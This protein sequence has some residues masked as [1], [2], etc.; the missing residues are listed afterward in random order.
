MI[1]K[2]E[3]EIRLL[4]LKVSKMANLAENMTEKSIEG[5]VKEDAEL[6]EEVILT[7]KEVDRIDNEIDEEVIRICA[8]RQP[9]AGDLRFIIASLKINVAIERVADNAVNIAEWSERIINKPKIMDYSDVVYMKQVAVEMFR[10]ALDAFFERDFEKSKVVIDRDIEVDNLE[11]K[12][13][14][15]L[16]KLSYSSS[17]NIK[18]ALRLT[19]IARALERI[20]DQATNI[21]EL[22]AFVAT[23]KVIKHKRIKE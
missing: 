16:I 1:G 17:S 23:G 18:S 20:A 9:E 19:F 12:I 2:I 22:A 4:K 14:K 11:M 21:A 13:M 7:D 15:D 3:D 10:D 5:L 6:L 8:L